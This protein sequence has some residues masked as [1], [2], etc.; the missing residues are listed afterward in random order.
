MSHKAAAAFDVALKRYLDTLPVTSAAHETITGFAQERSLSL[1]AAVTYLLE[2]ERPRL[3]RLAV[4]ESFKMPGMSAAGDGLKHAYRTKKRWARKDAERGEPVEDLSAMAHEVHALV[5]KG[6]TRQD[7]VAPSPPEDDWLSDYAQDN[8]DKSRT[9]QTK[10]HPDVQGPY[11]RDE[12]DWLF[13]D[14]DDA[15]ASNRSARASRPG[16]RGG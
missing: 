3:T 9:A 11:W 8:E 15:R 13:E 14:S 2:N 10:P 1:E 4:F 6:H 7:K 16:R 5:Q 12:D